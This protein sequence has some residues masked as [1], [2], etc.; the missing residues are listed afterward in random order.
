MLTSAG[1]Y[2]IMFTHV[3]RP[4]WAGKFRLSDG[5]TGHVLGMSEVPEV[6]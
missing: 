6:L 2:R 5:L 1:T 3:A 4:T